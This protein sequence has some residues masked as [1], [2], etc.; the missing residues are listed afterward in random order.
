MNES[1]AG[2]SMRI[3]EL[4]FPPT[5]NQPD[6]WVLSEEMIIV[7]LRFAVPSKEFVH[8]RAS[9]RQYRCV[10]L[11]GMQFYANRSCIRENRE[12]KRSAH[13][14]PGARFHKTTAESFWILPRVCMGHISRIFFSNRRFSLR[15]VNTSKIC[16]PEMLKISPQ[17]LLSRHR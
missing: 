4:I 3:E 9:H 15:D 2:G 8:A 13:P 10:Q 17:S 12:E 7:D 16:D 1:D 5:N 14:R 11:N 6:Q